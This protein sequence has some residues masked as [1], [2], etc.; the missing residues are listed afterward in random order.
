MP[1]LHASLKTNASPAGCPVDPDVCITQIALPNLHASL[2][3]K[4]SP[5]GCPVDPDVYITQK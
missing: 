4:E 1:N 2:K 5:A 3:T